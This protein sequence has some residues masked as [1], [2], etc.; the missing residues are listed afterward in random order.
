MSKNKYEYNFFVYPREVD[1]NKEM[2]LPAVGGA[3]LDAAGLAAR[4]KGFGMEQM[5]SEGLAWVVSRICIEMFSFPK[6]YSIFTAETWIENI[7]SL[8][9][10]RH[11]E[12]RNAD[13]EMLGKATSLWSLIDMER[14]RAVNLRERTEMLP[15]VEGSGI[16]IAA[17]KRVSPVIGTKELIHHVVC[18]DIDINCHVNSFKYV[19]WVLDTFTLAELRSLFIKRI[20]IN[21]IKEALFGEAVYLSKYIEDDVIN[22]ELSNEIGRAHV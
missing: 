10:T 4:E 1:V 13:G 2:T 17:P 9:S 6:E 11:F 21:Y 19:Q 18:S 16:D 12:L 7:S 15:Y 5:H 20:D 22:M 3:I 14:R 8:V